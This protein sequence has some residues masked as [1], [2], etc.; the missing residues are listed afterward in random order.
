M[1]NIK[2]IK[3]ED[4]RIEDIL[5]ALLKENLKEITTLSSSEIELPE[6]FNIGQNKLMSASSIENG[7]SLRLQTNQPGFKSSQKVNT[8][9]NENFHLVNNKS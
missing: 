1:N 6:T 5:K 7:V 4:H 3:S 2:F 9:R 8:V